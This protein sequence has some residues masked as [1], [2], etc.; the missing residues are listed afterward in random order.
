MVSP[1]PAEFYTPFLSE[2]AKE[3]KPSPIRGLYPLEARPGL[4]SL[5]AGKPN[6][7]TFP[8]TAITLKARSPT[9]P[10][11]EITT[12][13]DGAALAE[14]LQYGPTAGIPALIEWV[15]GLQEREHGRS[16]GEGWRVSIGSGSQDVIYKAINTVMNPGDSLLVES[17][18]YAG[19][20]PMFTALHLDL[21]EVETDSQ[22]ISSESLRSVLENWPAGKPKPKALYTVPYG[23]NPTGMTASLPR[24]QDVLAL[25]REHNFL[26][27]EDDPYYYLYYGAAPRVPSYF[28]LE[29]TAPDAGRVLRFDSLSKILSAGIRIGFL[30]G[31]EPLMAA[32]DMHTAVASLQTPSLTQSIAH[33]VL[34]A[35]GY[36]GFRAHT[37]RVSAFYRAKRDVFER[38]MRKHLAGLAE[39]DTPDAGMFFW[40]KLLIGDEGGEGDSAALIRTNAVERGVLALPG[41][42][43]LPNGR[44]T[45]YV[46]ASFSLLAP[47]DVDEAVKRLRDVVLD[48]KKGAA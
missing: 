11:V 47:A 29:R 41:T 39:W 35:W 34:G 48:A 25:A 23:C 9:D 19:V 21:I 36:D 10:D 2:A 17:P 6:A 46:R 44:A 24:R 38:A 3:R 33:A 45:A 26:I 20:I 13:L 30:C 18:V 4:I 22:G 27:L 16:K 15:H 1:L 42:V 14:G 31:P 5:L 8:L 12:E 37:E 28:A 40:F 43:F 7:T 32:I